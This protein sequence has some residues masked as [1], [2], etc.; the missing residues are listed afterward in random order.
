MAKVQVTKAWTVS[1]NVRLTPFVS[2]QATIGW[3]LYENKTRLL[4]A[5]WTIK[6]TCDGATGPG[7]AGDTVDRWASAANCQVLGAASG[8]AQS[9]AVLQNADGVQLL[10][11]LQ[12]ASYDIARVSMSQGGLFVPQSYTNPTNTY[13]PTATDEII[14]TLGTSVIGATASADRVMSIG[15]TNK[16][17]WCSCYRAGAITLYLACN[18]VDSACDLVVFAKPYVVAKLTDMTANGGGGFNAPF[19]T[20][21]SAPNNNYVY[22]TAGHRGVLTR[23]ITSGLP[24][25]LRVG[26]GMRAAPTGVG[27]NPMTRT[28]PPGEFYDASVQG[29][30]LTTPPALNNGTIPVFTIDWF[31][32]KEANMDGYLGSPI[33]WWYAHTSSYAL[34]ATGDMIAALAPGDTQATALRSNWLVALG[35]GVI[36]PWLNAAANLEIT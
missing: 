19:A 27:D 4:A 35:A 20:A 23:V 22:G 36:R 26:G 21:V 16:D 6:W 15:C 10:F 33:D 17:W 28:F 13:Q 32:A 31:G 3:W 7:G 14:A 11:T 34:P 1:P 12:G 9:W 24:R 29:H 25:N 8:D 30:S 5:G 2:L 18:Q